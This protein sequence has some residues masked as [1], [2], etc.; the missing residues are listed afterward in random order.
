M[1]QEGKRDKGERVHLVTHFPYSPF[2]L[3]PIFTGPPRR[4]RRRGSCPTCCTPKRKCK[5]IDAPLASG[6]PIVT[7]PAA[8]LEF[9]PPPFTAARAAYPAWLRGPLPRMGV[10]GVP[11]QCNLPRN[12]SR[13]VNIH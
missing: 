12:D 10:V 8:R 2:P 3:F 7:V 6:V 9:R 4:R 11:A 1:G 5:L 13:D